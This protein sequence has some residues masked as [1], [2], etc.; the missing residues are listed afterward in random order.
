MPAGITSA[1][2]EAAALDATNASE[3][4]RRAVLAKLREIGLPLESNRNTLKRNEQPHLRLIHRTHT[5]AHGSDPRCDWS[6]RK[7]RVRSPRLAHPQT[8]PTTSPPL[9]SRPMIRSFRRW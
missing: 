8:R 2:A 9:L 4:I 5:A 3:F 7:C 6:N 1:L